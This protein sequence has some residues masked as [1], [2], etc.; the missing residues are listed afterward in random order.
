MSPTVRLGPFTD[1][2]GAALR[3][4]EG[5]PEPFLRVEDLL[6][7]AELPGTLTVV[8]T[9]DAGE[10]V[11]LLQAAPEDGGLRSV[12]LFVHPGRRGV[13]YGRA[14]LRAAVAEPGFADSPLLAVIDR[15]NLASLRCFAACGFVPDP[16]ASSERYVH[17]VLAH[18]PQPA[19]GP[20][21]MAAGGN[22]G[23]LVACLVELPAMALRL[24]SWRVC[25]APSATS[26]PSTG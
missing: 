12:S 24:W 17:L 22:R 19:C 15:D 8:A 9:D 1:G 5:V 4:W 10:V 26:S 23:M 18:K 20:V 2:D 11:A 21:R 25:G 16:D 3:R 7:D 6:E 14:T 13:G